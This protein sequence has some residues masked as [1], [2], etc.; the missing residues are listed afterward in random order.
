M[1]YREKDEMTVHKIMEEME[2]MRGK[3]N[4]EKVDMSF[5]EINVWM[6]GRNLRYKKVNLGKNEKDL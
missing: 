2:E 4:F 5:S 6:K 1:W 3:T